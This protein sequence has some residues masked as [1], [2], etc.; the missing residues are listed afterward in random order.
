M[1][2]KITSCALHIRELKE[3]SRMYANEVCQ[4]FLY[5]NMNFIIVNNSVLYFVERGKVRVH[6]LK[7]VE[8]DCADFKIQK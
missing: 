6:N 2:I 3:A 7:L 5:F 8:F 1:A 4:L